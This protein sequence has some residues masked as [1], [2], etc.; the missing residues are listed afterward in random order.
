MYCTPQLIKVHKSLSR[1]ERHCYKAEHGK[2]RKLNIVSALLITLIS[3]S[4]HWKLNISSCNNVSKL[5]KR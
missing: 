5:E 1:L 4:L 2:I 3:D